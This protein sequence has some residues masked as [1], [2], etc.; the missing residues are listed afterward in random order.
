MFRRHPVLAILSVVYL[1]FVGWVTLNPSPPS[2]GAN[3]LL[4]RVLEWFG[5][6][7]ATE[8]ITLDR[9]EFLANI[10]LFVPV[11]VLVLL[12]LGRRWWWVGIVVGL[13]LTLG[14]EGAQQFMPARFPDVRDL[15]ANTAG[16]AIG[17]VLAL[18]ITTP[19]AIR[20]RPR[21]P[22]ATGG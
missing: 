20:N 16:A 21:H 12:F 14:I 11:G 4:R 7:E 9:F 5:R 22:A 6:H 2:P 13:V 15:V 19:A 10:A 18:L 3:R 1:A 17:A 8:W